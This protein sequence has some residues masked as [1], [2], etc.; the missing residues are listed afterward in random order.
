MASGCTAQRPA[1]RSGR[2]A[3]GYVL[4]HT[5]Y[6]LCHRSGV[7]HLTVVNPAQKTLVGVRGGRWAKVFCVI[8]CGTQVLNCHPLFGELWLLRGDIDPLLVQLGQQGRAGNLSV[9]CQGR[10]RP[11]P[12]KS[13]RG[14]MPQSGGERS[15]RS[16][17][18]VRRGSGRLR[19]LVVGVSRHY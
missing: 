14:R 8:P 10:H 19:R 5:H 2:T 7:R 11:W 1:L 12:T 3:L 6:G 17:T 16:T 9:A 13:L 15:A 18:A 4:P